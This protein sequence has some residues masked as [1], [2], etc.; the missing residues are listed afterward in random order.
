MEAVIGQT[1]MQFAERN[2]GA[3]VSTV[4]DLGALVSWPSGGAGL[5]WEPCVCVD[6]SKTYVIEIR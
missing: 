5:L 4:L 2:F 1:F 6:E 3:V